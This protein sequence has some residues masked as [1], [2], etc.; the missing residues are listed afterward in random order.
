MLVICTLSQDIITVGVKISYFCVLSTT[1]DISEW[2]ISQSRLIAILI[3]S[4]D[5]I[6]IIIIKR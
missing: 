2:S 6:E 4:T 3:T 5:I 1:A